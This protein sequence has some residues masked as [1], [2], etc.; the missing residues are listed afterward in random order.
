M[1]YLFT[2]RTLHTLLITFFS[3]FVLSGC[4]QRSHRLS[5]NSST[6]ATYIKREVKPHIPLSKIVANTDP[7]TPWELVELHDPLTFF[8]DVETDDYSFWLVHGFLPASFLDSFYPG[9]F[10]F[11]KD[12]PLVIYGEHPLSL[13]LTNTSTKDAKNWIA[14]YPTAASSISIRADALCDSGLME[15][16]VSA[17]NKNRHNQVRLDLVGDEPLK[18]NVLNCLLSLDDFEKHITVS[19]DNAA[20]IESFVA[21]KNLKSLS[22]FMDGQ[23]LNSIDLN[24]LFS[25][26]QTTV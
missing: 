26:F 3:I 8:L 22:L 10:A 2:Q 18:K 21:M 7:K 4:G 19:L 23:K 16:F 9:D 13:E 6:D 5:S 1:F 17:L 20:A 11:K 12:G 15:T 24:R 14:R 25:K